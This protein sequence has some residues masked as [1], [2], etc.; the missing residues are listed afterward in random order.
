MVISSSSSDLS[1]IFSCHSRSP[2]YRLC[3]IIVSTWF[4]D[5][6]PSTYFQMQLSLKLRELWKKRWGEGMKRIHFSQ[7]AVFQPTLLWF[8]TTKGSFPIFPCATSTCRRIT[9]EKKNLKIEFF[10][11]QGSGSVIIKPLD[12]WGPKWQYNFKSPYHTPANPWCKKNN[13][14]LPVRIFK[15]TKNKTKKI[16]E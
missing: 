1:Q 15:K 9:E 14:S 5:R 6:C 13:V 10:R 16:L 12:H 3:I 2:C 8:P 4:G 11:S 7:A